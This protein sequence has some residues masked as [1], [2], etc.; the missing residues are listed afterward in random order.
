MCWKILSDQH[1]DRLGEGIL[2]STRR[3]SILWV[4]IVGQWLQELSLET[5]LMQRWAMPER[6]G[7]VVERKSGDLL[8]GLKGGVAAL[9]LNPFHLKYVCAPE[10][11]RP[12][13]RLNDAAVDVQGNLWFGTKDDNDEQVSGAL[14]RMTADFGYSRQDDGYRV[15]NGPVFSADGRRFWHSD[16]SARIVYMFDLDPHGNVVRRNE[17]LRFPQNWGLPDGMSLDVDGGLWIAHWGGGRVSRFTPDAK[18]DRA[19]ALP[20]ANITNVAFGGKG[21]DRMFV[22]SAQGD[23][24]DSSY[25]GALFEIDP[26]VTGLAPIPFGG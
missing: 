17:F 9:T 8:V 18:L 1:R 2:W 21:L 26:A 25:A 24:P 15:P 12:Q 4:D 7:W 6:I 10:V 23:L 19:V 11:D 22:T 13:N 5:G 20:T 3:S 16:S 14:Y